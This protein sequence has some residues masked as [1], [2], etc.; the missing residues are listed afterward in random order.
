MPTR[1][2][3]VLALRLM[4]QAWGSAVITV[5]GAGIAQSVVCWACCPEWCSAVDSI[6]LWAS[7]GGDFSLGLNMDYDSIRQKL[8]GIKYKPRSGLYHTC[9]PWHGLKRSWRSCPR[10][11]N[12]GNKNSSSMHHPRRRNV[13]T[14]MAGLKKK[15][16]SQTQKSHQNGETQ[17]YSWERRRR[18]RST[19]N[20]L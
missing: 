17:R 3:P 13:T 14:S 12:V 1:G 7:G 18:R 19:P 9:F 6:R 20:S 15:K 10:R 11:V 4:H 2:Q 5:A 8:F 16:R